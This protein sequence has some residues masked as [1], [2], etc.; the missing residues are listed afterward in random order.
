MKKKKTLLIG[1]IILGMSEES[2]IVNKFMSY[3]A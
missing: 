2:I 1:E 3:R